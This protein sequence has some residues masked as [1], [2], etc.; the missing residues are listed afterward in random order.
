MTTKKIKIINI[1]ARL[2]FLE[3]VDLWATVQANPNLRFESTM[4]GLLVLFANNKKYI[5]NRQ[6]IASAGFK[7]Q[8]EAQKNLQQTLQKIKLVA[9]KKLDKE[10]D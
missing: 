8:Q 10:V 7:S 3:P 4:K 9:I 6:G 5:I 1:C 2:Q